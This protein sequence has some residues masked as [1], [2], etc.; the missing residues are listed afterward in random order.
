VNA[1]WDFVERQAAGARRLAAIDDCPGSPLAAVPA[2]LAQFDRVPPAAL[3]CR[4]TVR[5]LLA[6]NDLNQQGFL[7]I[8]RRSGGCGCRAGEIDRFRSTN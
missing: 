4:S 5:H 3:L 2:R 1:A 8:A 6:A 7:D